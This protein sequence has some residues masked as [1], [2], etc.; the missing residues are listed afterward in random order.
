[1]EIKVGDIFKYL[2]PK[3]LDQIDDYAEEVVD[4]AYEEVVKQERKGYFINKAIQA[5]KKHRR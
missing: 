2:T 3:D 1:M 5:K 4:K